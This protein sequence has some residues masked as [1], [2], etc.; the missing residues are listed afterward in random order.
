[1]HVHNILKIKLLWLIVLQCITTFI[2]LV[3]GRK[4]HVKII[5]GCDRLIFAR[6]IDAFNKLIVVRVDKERQRLTNLVSLD[7]RFRNQHAVFLATEQAF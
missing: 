7:F 2:V 3:C 6:S 1:M 5:Q 4:S